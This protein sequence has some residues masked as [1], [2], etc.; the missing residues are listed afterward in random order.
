MGETSTPRTACRASR[1]SSPPFRGDTSSVASASQ[2]KRSHSAC[3]KAR[4]LTETRARDARAAWRDARRAPRKFGMSVPATIGQEPCVQV[5]V[6]YG[7]VTI[8]RQRVP[9]SPLLGVQTHPLAL[10][11]V[12]RRGGRG[13][14]SRRPRRRRSAARAAHRA[15]RPIDDDVGRRHRRREAHAVLGARG[16]APERASPGSA[17]QA[18]RARAALCRRAHPRGQLAQQ[19]HVACCS[20][21]RAA[22]RSRRSRSGRARTG[23]TSGA[24]EVGLCGRR[25]LAEGRSS[26][27]IAS[28]SSSTPTHTRTRRG[29]RPRAHSA[30][31]A[32]TR[33]R[34]SAASCAS[35]LR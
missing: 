29:L 7:I 22:A 28:I 5:V 19:Q 34:A 6:I 9:S 4:G 30:S 20:V 16:A 10:S 1:T 12:S 14:P 18:R 31:T 3:E 33:A 13:G 32:R 21:C 11:L 23:G 2:L 26:F 8:A 24:A 25:R 17:G 27:A 15:G 35:S